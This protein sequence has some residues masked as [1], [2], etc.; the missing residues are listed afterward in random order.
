MPTQQP[1]GQLCGVQPSFGSAQ[2]PFEQTLPF[3]QVSQVNPAMPHAKV[4]FPGTHEP[5]LSMHPA[6]L[7]ARQR[8][9]PQACEGAQVSQAL[10][11]APQLND[12]SEGAM[13]SP[14]RQQPAQLNAHASALHPPFVQASP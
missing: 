12:V 5:L 9:W 10:P 6:Q 1:L 4:V 8:P 14:S 13:H 11:G 2:P 7:A 3:E